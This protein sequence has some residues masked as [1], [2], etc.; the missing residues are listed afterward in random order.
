MNGHP[1][2]HHTYTICQLYDHEFNHV[3]TVLSIPLSLKFGKWAFFAHPLESLVPGACSW[4][5]LFIS[6]VILSCITGSSQQST[7]ACSKNISLKFHCKLFTQLLYLRVQ[8]RVCFDARMQDEEYICWKPLSPCIYKIN[9]IFML[10]CFKWRWSNTLFFSPMHF[11]INPPPIF[12]NH[13]RSPPIIF[14]GTSRICFP[15][16]SCK[17]FSIL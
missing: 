9:I 12:P 4:I 10:A 7:I 6:T 2:Q 1:S 16:M 5:H 11:L 13:E 3:S 15:R 17:I 14:T 8:L